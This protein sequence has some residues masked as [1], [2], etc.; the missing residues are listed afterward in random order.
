MVLTG[1]DSIVGDRAAALRCYNQARAEIQNAAN[2]NHQQLFY[3][4][5][6][7]SVIADPTFNAGWQ[8]VGHANN[9]LGVLHGA[10]AAYR[11][12]LEF[13]DGPGEYD[14]N[15]RRRGEILT[16]IGHLLQRI[17][18]VDEAVS[19]L[20][21]ALEIDRTLSLAWMNMSL[22]D[23]NQGRLE[24]SIECAREAYR[25]EPTHP[26]IEMALAFALMFTGYYSEGLKHF[27]SRFAYK[28]RSFLSYPFPKW[29]GSPDKSVFLVGDQGIGDT[30]SFARFVERAAKK[31]KFIH[32][33]VQQELVRLFA[34]S[35][36]HIPNLNIIALP[37]P[38]PPA[39]CWSTFVSLPSC[40]NLTDE[41]IVNEPGIR[42]PPF[43]APST[44][45]KSPDRKYHIGVSWA[46]SKANEID[47]W[48]SFPLEHLLELY[49]VPGIQLYSLQVG[50]RAMELHNAGCATLLR[51][52]NPLIRDVS[53]TMGILPHLDLVIGCESIL[54]HICAAMN[55]EFWMAYS[56]HGRDFRTGYDGTKRLWT[57]KHRIFKQDRDAQWAPV[58]ERITQALRERVENLE[59]LEAAE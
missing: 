16:T 32:M 59:Q 8:E 23:Q 27:E 12:V 2:P 9:N 11:R 38:W 45:W 14:L 51:D 49:R 28:L 13:P 1:E 50:D 42:I 37:C 25:Q 22:C 35:F 43:Q 58:F 3:Q 7:S 48:R 57:P 24:S 33:A 34:A 36:Q 54:G 53:D 44:S 19:C 40:M 55:K 56:W 15:P 20:A 5:M 30:L 41:E 18:M 17:G 21:Q 26:A 31:S 39:D 52:L 29:D 47:R 46:G 6:C 4:L 10:I